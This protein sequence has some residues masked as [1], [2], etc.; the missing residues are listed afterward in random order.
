[1]NV[2]ECLQGLSAIGLTGRV[3]VT[4]HP[5]YTRIFVMKGVVSLGRIVIFKGLYTHVKWYWLQ[6]GELG[7]P[8][9]HIFRWNY[10]VKTG[11]VL[12]QQQY[13][14]V[15]FK[16]KELR[17]QDFQERLDWRREHPFKSD[18][19]TPAKR[20]PLSRKNIRRWMVF[21]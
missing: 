19:V 1:M 12:T 14:E 9:L 13:N 21:E 5:D 20:K 2:E 18:G 15:Y 6:E 10:W 17:E 8:D 11:K 4:G 3:Q 16:A 7:E